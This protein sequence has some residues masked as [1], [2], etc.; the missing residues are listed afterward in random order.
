MTALCP[1]YTL[2]LL[3][4][5]TGIWSWV[6]LDNVCIPGVLEPATRGAERAGAKK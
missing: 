6:G 1:T 3:V 4:T 5:G 2:D